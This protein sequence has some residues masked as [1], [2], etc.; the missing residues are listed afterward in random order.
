[1]IYCYSFFKNMSINSPAVQDLH[2]IRH[3]LYSRRRQMSWPQKKRDIEHNI[4]NFL[5]EFN[6]KLVET[7]PGVFKLKK[8]G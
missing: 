6:L 2:T 8:I 3:N 7:G 1:M 5:D 4:K